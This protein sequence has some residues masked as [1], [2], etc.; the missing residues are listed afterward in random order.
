[1]LITMVIVMMMLMLLFCVT[2]QLTAKFPF[3]VDCTKAG[4]GELGVDITHNGRPVPTRISNTATSAYK[5]VSFRPHEAGTYEINVH[6]NKAEVRG[7]SSHVIVLMMVTIT[8]LLILP[9]YPT[10]HV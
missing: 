10:K 3:S 1:M 6:F 4:P 2:N 5:Q 9:S 8:T 7:E